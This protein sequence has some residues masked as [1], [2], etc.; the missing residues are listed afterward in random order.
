[1]DSD[2]VTAADF[3]CGYTLTVTLFCCRIP[4]VTV[5]ATTFVRSPDVEAV[6][7]VGAVTVVIITFVDI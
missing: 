6:G 7:V 2:A 1:M 5:F 4:T 3:R